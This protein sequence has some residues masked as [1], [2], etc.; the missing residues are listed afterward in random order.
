MEGNAIMTSQM[1][2]NAIK[3]SSM[4]VEQRIL[5]SEYKSVQK[6]NVTG[7]WTKSEAIEQIDNWHHVIRIDLL[8]NIAWDKT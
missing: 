7:S 4:E 6:N 2:G 8:G 1:D 3:M 5:C